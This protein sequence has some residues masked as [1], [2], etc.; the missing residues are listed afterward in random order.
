MI[1]RVLIAVAAGGA[2][3]ALARWGLSAWI[4]RWA[5]VSF[6][7]A[8]LAVNAAGCLFLGMV[9]RVVEGSAPGAAWRVFL[10]VGVAGGFTTF[11]TFSHE[12]LLLLQERAYVRAALYMSGSM[13]LGI[14]GLLLGLVIAD[15]LVRR[16]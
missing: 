6:P 9:L 14:C 12:S 16:G 15:E 7:W 8:T 13:V 3:G 11:S 10:T 5:P 4:G 2:V 1:A